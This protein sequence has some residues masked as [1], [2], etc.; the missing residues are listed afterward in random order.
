MQRKGDLAQAAVVFTG[1]KND[2]VA[3]A[4][5]APPFASNGFVPSRDVVANKARIANAVWENEFNPTKAGKT[6]A[7]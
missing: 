2:V 5:R 1:D 6:A 4:H 7:S 3:F